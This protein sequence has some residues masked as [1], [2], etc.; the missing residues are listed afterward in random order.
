MRYGFLLTVKV[1]LLAGSM[2]LWDQAMRKSAA[3]E[4][5][6]IATTVEAWPD[7]LSAAQ[8]YLDDGNR[9]AGAAT[10]VTLAQLVAQGYLPSGSQ[11]FNGFGAGFTLTGTPGLHGRLVARMETAVPSDLYARVRLALGGLDV[12]GGAISLLSQQDLASFKGVAHRS[13]GGAAALSGSITA[14]LR[15]G[16]DVGQ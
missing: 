12:A 15:T 1:A 16:E 2:S 4:E 14:P 6:R 10:I 11:D 8:K 9:P 5:R 7:V 3:L 13:A